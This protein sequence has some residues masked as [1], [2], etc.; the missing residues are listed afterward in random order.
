MWNARCAV[1]LILGAVCSSRAEALVLCAPKD[2]EGSVK[3]REAC[4]KN[5]TQLDPVALGL[6]GPPGPK[7]DTG[8]P[9]PPGPMGLQGDRGLQGLQGEK[10]EKGD[11]GLQGIAGP[12]GPG[13]AVKDANGVFVGVVFDRGA[14]NFA[15][16][17][18]GEIGVYFA[19]T[20][21][22][23]PESSLVQLDHEST[24]CSGPAFFPTNADLLLFRQG[25]VRGTTLYYA[26]SPA[27]MP[28]SRSSSD[29]PV[30]DNTC[31]EVFIPPNICC[32]QTG[33][34]TF[35]HYPA[36]TI[37]LSLFIPPFHVEVLE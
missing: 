2:G 13:A 22:G 7:G 26:S 14:P 36:G 8:N 20:E 33:P 12:P 27:V 29:T 21:E 18:V 37:D 5:E 10:G 1:V 19:V 24:D 32:S 16:R 31:G 30:P 34:Q 28:T 9:G 11:R 25:A 15:L 23:I 35:L 6:Q 3:V 4:K 17:Q